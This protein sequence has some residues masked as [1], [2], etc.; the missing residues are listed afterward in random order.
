MNI[1]KRKYITTGLPIPMLK[2]L[3]DLGSN[4]GEWEN[5]NITN[6]PIFAYKKKNYLSKTKHLTGDITGDDWKSTK[7]QINNKQPGL[8]EH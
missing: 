3:K 6:L 5:F 8:Y 7:L 2:E 4:S 1:E